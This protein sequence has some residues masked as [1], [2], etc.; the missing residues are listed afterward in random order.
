MLVKKVFYAELVSNAVKILTVL[1]FILPITELF[2]QLEQHSSSNIPA[3]TLV[4]LMTY[5]TIASFPQILTISCFLTVVFTINR[6]CKDHEFAVWLSSGISPFFWLRQVSIFAIPFAV[7][8]AISSMYITPWATAKSNQYAEYLSN[9]QAN[10]FISPGVFK[11]NGDAVF[12]L[13]HYSLASGFAKNIFVQYVNNQGV[14]YNITALDGKVE[15]ANGLTSLILKDGQRYQISGEESAKY[16]KIDLSFDE[17]KAS[18][19]QN[20]TLPK[21]DNSNISTSSIPYLFKTSNEGNTNARAELSWR[22]SIALMIFVMTFIVVPIS[23]QFGRIQGHLVFI[24]PPIIYA[25]YNNLILTLNSYVNQGR[26]PSMLFV[27]AIHILL[28]V[29]AILLTYYKTYP[30]GSVLNK[31]KSVF[32]KD[33][34]K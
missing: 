26:L 16:S 11:E 17:L 22:I 23:M 3:S 8:C 19:K 21:P 20:Y 25:I 14:T 4:T 9:Q 18:I 15:N 6:Y 33:I 5:G 24:V 7:I 12:Y 1:L 2:K 29:V 10:M 13:D 28:I 30:K 34:N 31:I 32:N 27:Q